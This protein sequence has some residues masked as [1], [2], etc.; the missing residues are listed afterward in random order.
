MWGLGDTFGH[1]SAS[2]LRSINVNL[3]DISREEM[4][5]KRVIPQWVILNTAS[6]GFQ[7]VRRDIRE[8]KE[9][10]K[11]L[12]LRPRSADVR[13]QIWKEISVGRQG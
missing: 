8:S 6:D 10:Q 11:V 5:R 9:L 7:S 4:L 1:R 3:P 2:A 12:G 13:I